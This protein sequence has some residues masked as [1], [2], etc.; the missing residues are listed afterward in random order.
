M[1]RTLYAVEPALLR[2][3]FAIDFAKDSF[4]DREL[5][6]MTA[7]IAMAMDSALSSGL[8]AIAKAKGWAEPVAEKSVRKELADDEKAGGSVHMQPLMPVDHSLDSGCIGLDF[9]GSS[10]LKTVASKF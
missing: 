5:F 2:K 6:E 3:F 10:T 4:R 9:A 8:V 1:F 7:P